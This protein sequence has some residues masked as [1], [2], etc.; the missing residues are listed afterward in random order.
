M[1]YTLAGT[2]LKSVAQ[3]RDLGLQVVSNLKKNASIVDRQSKAFCA[4]YSM[5]RAVSVNSVDLLIKC[6]KTYVL[7]HIEFGSTFYS[8]YLTKDIDAIERVQRAFTKILYYR[9]FSSDRDSV[10]DYDQRLKVL[11]LMK[12]KERRKC[13]DAILAFRVMTL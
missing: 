13:S 7:P 1:T 4:L 2:T 11:G 9:C 5:L 3:V 12:L 6:Y 10:P 8:P